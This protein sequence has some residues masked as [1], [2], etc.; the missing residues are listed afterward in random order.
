MN[1]VIKAMVKTSSRFITFLRSFYYIPTCLFYCTHEVR[2]LLHSCIRVLLHSY[3]P[4]L[5]HSYVRVLLHSYVRV[6]LHA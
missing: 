6:L 1:T 4:V 3:V 2:V 5:L